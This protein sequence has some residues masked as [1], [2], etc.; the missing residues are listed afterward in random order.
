MASPK[1]QILPDGRVLILRRDAAMILGVSQNAMAK[2]VARGEL[3]DLFVTHRTKR[4]YESEVM[5]LKA[6]RDDD[7]GAGDSMPTTDAELLLSTQ[8]QRQLA[9]CSKYHDKLIAAARAHVLTSD[10]QRACDA[11]IA[12]IDKLIDWKPDFYDALTNKGRDVLAVEL[13]D[14]PREARRM[15]GQIVPEPLDALTRDGILDAGEPLTDGHLR[16]V[17]G[18]RAMLEISKTHLT[19]IEVALGRQQ[20]VPASAIKMNLENAAVTLKLKVSNLRTRLLPHLKPVDRS[21]IMPAIIELMEVTLE[22]IEPHLPD[23]VLADAWKKGFQPTENLTVSEWSAKYRI[24]SSVSSAEPGRW[25]NERTPYL[26]EI[27]DAISNDETRAITCMLASQLGK[28]EILLNALGYV[29]HLDPSPVMLIQPDLTMAASFSKDR[30][31]PMIGGCPALLDKV[32]EADE[33]TKGGAVQQALSKSFPGGTLALAGSN[34]AASLASRPIRVLMADEADR[35]PISAGREGSPLEL[36]RRRTASFPD[37]KKV[38]VTSTPTIKGESVV[39]SLFLQ[40][41]QEHL[42]A[43]CP[44]CGFA[45]ILS[46]DQMRWD[47]DKPETAVYQCASDDCGTLWDDAERQEAVAAGDWIAHNPHVGI[48]H[49]GFWLNGLYSPFYP[50]KQIVAE[51]LAAKKDPMVMRT[52]VNTVLAQS[53]SDDST[54]IEEESITNRFEAF[55]SESIPPEVLALTVGVDVQANRLE[56]ILT[57]WTLDGTAL[58]LGYFVLPGDPL[59]SAT[60]D[61]L[62]EITDASYIHPLTPDGSAMLHI[63]AVAVDSGYQTVRVQEWCAER[64][65]QRFAIK[66]VAGQRPVWKMSTSKKVKA[67]EG[68]T[69]HIVGV[70]QVKEAVFARLKRTPGDDGSVRIGTGVELAMDRKAFAG[71]ILSEYRTI[72]PTKTGRLRIAWVRKPGARSEVLDTFGYSYACFEGTV[73]SRADWSGRRLRLSGQQSDPS[74]AL[75]IE[76]GSAPESKAP[77]LSVQ[78]AVQQRRPA[79]QAATRPSNPPST[80]PTNPKAPTPSKP[81]QWATF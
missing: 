68:H 57:G 33:K 31:Q 38:L 78:A 37:T 67:A 64:P 75:A 17:T 63:D 11:I 39:E 1:A 35:Y 55:C 43:K 53:W 36:A 27:M 49:R 28:S 9:N 15:L 48:E 5:A 16:T 62:A 70:D 3:T 60:W 7:G 65:A 74:A 56:A 18:I 71:Q 19:E 76:F 79:A 54:S 26:V 44:H 13:R 21:M 69:L 66:G 47:D 2:T 73:R 14:I 34:S 72:T 25:R 29:I 41:T 52:F 59:D 77:P 61:Q 40:S 46:F 22:K 24:L 45:Q 51:F 58:I 81:V 32:A 12:E 6:A 80:E 4:V 23:G 20:I 50:G 8:K 42:Y 10:A 30:L